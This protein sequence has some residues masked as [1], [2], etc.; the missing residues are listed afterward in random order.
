M[1]YLALVAEI[2]ELKRVNDELRKEVESL[3]DGKQKKKPKVEKIRCPCMTA[4]GVQCSKYCMEGANT[5]KVHSRPAKPPKQPKPPR[6]KKQCCTFLNMRGNPC[7]RK[8]IDGQTFCERHDPSLPVVQKKVKRNVKKNVPV[9]NH[10]PGEIPNVP[11]MLCGTHGDMF[12]SALIGD[13]T[14]VFGSDGMTLRSRLKKI[15]T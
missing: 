15:A 1:E 11:C 14:E 3:R 6:A 9:H 5:C 4:K 2:E 12:N 7:K 8:C 10:A 13:I